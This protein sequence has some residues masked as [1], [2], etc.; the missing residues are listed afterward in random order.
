MIS[1]A[2]RVLTS[3]AG[4]LIGIAGALF[5]WHSI[6]KGSA[7]RAAVVGYVAET[8]LRAA[9]ARAD[10]LEGRL[11]RLSAANALLLEQ[12]ERAEQEARDA[13]GAREKYLERN[14]VPPA[15]CAVSPD[16]LD[17]LR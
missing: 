5:A 16:L 6:D 17:L 14:P 11:V 1:L 10:I 3:R 7:V 9:S 8:E 15:D 13:E 12:V 4:L 2:L